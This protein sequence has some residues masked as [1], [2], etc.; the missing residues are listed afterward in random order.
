[1]VLGIYRAGLIPPEQLEALKHRSSRQS[2]DAQLFDQ[3]KQIAE[4][5]RAGGDGAVLDATARSIAC[6]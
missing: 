3:A 4:S 6:R 2:L 5:V 1:M